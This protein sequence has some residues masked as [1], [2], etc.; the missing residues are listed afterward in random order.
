MLPVSVMRRLAVLLVMVTACAS[1]APGPDDMS[2]DRHRL[3]AARERSAARER[4]LAHGGRA[5]T[6]DVG[7]GMLPAGLIEGGDAARDR[8][9]A[10]AYLAHARLHEAAADELE[11]QE[12]AACRGLALEERADCPE[13]RGAG[14]VIDVK[15]GIEIRFFHGAPVDEVERRMRCHLAFAKAHGSGCPLYGP[16]ATI[17]RLGPRV[18]RL[19]RAR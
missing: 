11:R 7:G 2:A 18:V 1:A 6:A 8:S 5:R 10:D 3:E 15:D 14:A 19:W 17:E 4:L 9:L 13:L 12:E 16:G